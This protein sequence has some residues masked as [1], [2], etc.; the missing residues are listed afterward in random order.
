MFDMGT[1]A[2]FFGSN[3]KHSRGGTTRHLLCSSFY[4]PGLWSLAP[5]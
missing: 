2:A 5:F 3:F 4:Y 1:V